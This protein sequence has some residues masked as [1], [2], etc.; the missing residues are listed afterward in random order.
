MTDELSRT[1]AL[2]SRHTA[3]G[4]GLEDWNGMGTPWSYSTDPRDEHDAIRE[5]AGMFDVS[6]LKKVRV[7]GPDAG[8]VIDHTHSRDLTRVAPGQSAYGCV[9]TEAGKVADDAIAFNNGDAGWL[10]VHGTGVSMEMLEASA[11]GRE[12]EIELD[13]DMHSISLQGP[14]SMP[15]LNANASVDLDSVPYFHHVD[16]DLFGLSTT[17]SRT[18]FTGERGYEI[19]V[20]AADVGSLWDAILAAGADDGVMAAS[21]TALDK[22]RVEAA[23]LFFG[24]D[25]TD[26]HFPSEVGLGWS[27]SKFG[28][29]YR[30][31]A[32]A[33]A[34]VGSERFAGAGFSIDHDDILEGGETIRV[35]GADVGTINSS[36][37]S[38]RLGKSLALGHIAHTASAV[39]TVVE[40]VGESASYSGTVEAIPFYDPSKGRTHA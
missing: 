14:A 23:L 3:L 17:V 1:S 37:Y 38:H 27:I 5:A 15:L 29:D 30:G 12:V 2:A 22:V 20:A 24:Y 18:G 35:N 32:A 10:F 11:E 7:S 21:F 28:A 40:V 26:E 33:L 16:T 6:P 19:F 9:L 31:K 4:S 25:M 36:A 39:G 13:D 34:A 8:A